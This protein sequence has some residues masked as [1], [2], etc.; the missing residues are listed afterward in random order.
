MTV[1][2]FDTLGG[3]MQGL[4]PTPILSVTEW[5][6]R[7]RYLASESSAE[8]G[9]WRTERTPYL[10]E[11]G[12]CMGPNSPVTDLVVVK[13]VQLGFTENGLNIVGSYLD[14]APCPIMYVM[15]TIDMAKSLSKTRLTP[16]VANCP[17]LRDKIK[18]NSTKDSG[19]TILEK[20]VPGG[21]IALAG[22]NSASALSSKPVKVLV[23]DETDRYPLS[24]DDEGS[25]IDL[26]IKRTSTFGKKRKIYQLSTPTLEE[27]SVIMKAYLLTDQRKYFVPCPECGHK[28]HLVFDQLVYEKIK[29]DTVL[30]GSVKY[31]CQACEYLIDERHKTNIMR[32]G[33]GEWI[34]TCPENIHPTKRGYHINSLY[35]PIGWLSWEDI[36]TQWLAAQSDVNKLRVFINTILGETWKESGESPPWENIYNRRET[37]GFNKPSKD[38]VFITEGVDVQKDRLEIEVVGWCRDKVSQSLDYRIIHG[39]T[40]QPAVWTELKKYVG[41]VWTRE[42]GI[43]LPMRLM[44]VDANYNTQHVYSFCKQFDQT[45]VIP[46]RGSDSQNVIITQPKQVDITHSGK[47]VGAVKVWTVGVSLLKSELYGYLKQEISEDGTLPPG[48]CRFPQ[49]EPAYFRGITAEKLQSKTNKKG[50]LT[51]E[52][53]KKYE[54]NEPLDLRNYARAAASVLG[55][56][57]F[58]SENWDAMDFLNTGP[59]TPAQ[60]KKRPSFWDKR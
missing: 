43:Q 7:N 5:S 11:P 15:P 45:R 41:E 8:P 18:S 12:D 59:V 56:D 35:S 58:S 2:S 57:R 28:Q 6:D 53:V 22:A 29:S 37:Y 10:E 26:A 16:M 23:L 13:G 24:V 25:P 33:Q 20:S 39:D 47:K 1:Q 60:T 34:P 49:Y 46:V 19:N 3:L 44:A 52:W 27:T 32:K 54:R 4:R 42:D 21:L 14:I 40:S 17:N 50:Y 38:V 31:K 51:Y 9:R 30:P 48:Y 36:I 55:M